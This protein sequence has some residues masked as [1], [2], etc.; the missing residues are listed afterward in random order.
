MLGTFFESDLVN[1]WFNIFFLKDTTFKPVFPVIGVDG[2]TLQD[3]WATI[4]E[5]YFSVGAPGFPNY[6]IVIGPNSPLGQNSLLPWLEGTVDWIAEII[7]KMQQEGIKSVDPDREITKKWNDYAQN[8]LKDYVW[9]ESC[10]AW[11][12][13]KDGS[14]RVTA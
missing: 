9:S 2:R 1:L 3:E 8:F 5:S 6:F 13:A 12:K 11:Y 4:P 14:G 7:I 10:A